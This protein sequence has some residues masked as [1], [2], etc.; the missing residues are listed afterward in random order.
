MRDAVL[1]P[2]FTFVSVSWLWISEEI[3]RFNGDWEIWMRLGDD[4]F[5]K[6]SWGLDDVNLAVSDE[7]VGAL[8][9][10]IS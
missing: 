1:I 5:P 9:I 8:E 6:I 4:F 3:G 7:E 10:F 2:C